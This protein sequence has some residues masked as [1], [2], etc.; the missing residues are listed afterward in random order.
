MIAAV[1]T[2]DMLIERI[3]VIAYS[4]ANVTMMV[5]V[6]FDKYISSLKY[7]IKE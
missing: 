4:S 7:Y 6:N 2:T 1:V 3:V 5:D